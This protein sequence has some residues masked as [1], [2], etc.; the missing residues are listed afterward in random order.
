MDGFRDVR[1]AVVHQHDIGSL[2]CGVGTHRAHRDA[3]VGAGE[4]RRVVD[5][6]AHEREL[7][8]AGRLIEQLL[9]CSHL[10]LRQQLCAVLVDAE[11]G[12][13]GCGHLFAI[14]REHDGSLHP[15]RMELGD[16]LGG[17]LL[18]HIGDYDMADVFAVERHMQNR[19]G[20]LAIVVVHTAFAHELVVAHEHDPLVDRS[21]YAVAAPLLHISDALAVDRSRVGLLDRQGDRVVGVRFGV[22]R[23]RQDEVGIDVGFGM[24]RDHAERTVGERPRLIEHDR[25]GIAERLEVVASLHEDAEPR[26]TADAAEERKR[27]GDNERA[28]ARNHKEDQT[29]LHPVRPVLAEQ[30]RRY[31]RKQH[32]HDHDGGRVVAREPRDEVLGASLLLARVLDEFEDARDGRL[33]ER[34][35][36]LYGQKARHVDAPRNDL[37]TRLDVARNRLAGERRG[38][39]LRRARHDHTVERNALARLHDDL[40]AHGD[41]VRIHLYKLAVAHDVGVVGRD[42]HH[43]GDRFARFADRIALEQLAY[44]IEQ[45]DCSAL[46][47]MRI[48]IGKQHERERADGRHAHEEVLVEHLAVPDVS[49]RFEQHVVARDQVRNEEEREL[50]VEPQGAPEPAFERQRIYDSEQHDRNNDADERSLLLLI[51]GFP[52]IRLSGF[53]HKDRPRPSA[54]IT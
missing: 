38:I 54:N 53:G 40:V 31:D 24:N 12:S 5:A 9:D 30:Q 26:R 52:F 49:R 17:I 46:G 37:G 29:A 34:L 3:D 42:I 14:A 33:A 39:E 28:G 16:G 8:L 6:V 7:A 32:G 1:G 36:H 19:A 43:V 44:L 10:I 48:G 22:R 13:H 20:Q 51:H 2:D 18:D 27:H 50:D 23:Y 11:L 45:H 47:H 41:L 25:L 21:A 15:H 35:G 4:H